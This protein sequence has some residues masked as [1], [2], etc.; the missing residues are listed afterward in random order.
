MPPEDQLEKVQ[1]QVREC[2]VVLILALVCIGLTIGAVI[3]YQRSSSNVTIR[4]ERFVLVDVEG[5]ELGEWWVN[6]FAPRLDMRAASGSRGLYLHVDDD[7]PE[8]TGLSIFGH[9]NR[10]SLRTLKTSSGNGGM[11]ELQI[12]KIDD[13][14]DIVA[15]EDLAPALRLHQDGEARV[16]AVAHTN[17][18]SIDV[19]LGGDTKTMALPEASAP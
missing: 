8:A 12:G 9:G 14:A 2:R 6:G 10:V 19:I 11:A 16:R 5:R 17:S 4:A 15:G 1:R 7:S 18:S 3:A 13:Y